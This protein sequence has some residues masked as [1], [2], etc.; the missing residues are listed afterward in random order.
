MGVGPVAILQAGGGQSRYERV[1]RT[2][3]QSS[4]VARRSAG[5]TVPSAPSSRGCCRI[6]A[7]GAW[8]SL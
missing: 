5:T 7:G 2:G 4:T 1:R 8:A 6:P 3:T